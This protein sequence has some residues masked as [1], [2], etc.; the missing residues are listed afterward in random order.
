MKLLWMHGV[1]SASESHFCVVDDAGN[2]ASVCGH[3]WLQ[4]PTPTT[5]SEVVMSRCAECAKIDMSGEP[6]IAHDS[7]GEEV[8]IREKIQ[9]AHAGSADPF[10]DIAEQLKKM[11]V[12]YMLIVGIQGEHRARYFTNI[13]EFG[14]P[15]IAHFRAA[16]NDTLDK[17]DKGLDALG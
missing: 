3:K 9:P 11:R 6:I 5:P 2:V 4:A 8:V 13:Y 12:A 17:F 14:K 15:G 10:Y 1:V 16:A 7:G